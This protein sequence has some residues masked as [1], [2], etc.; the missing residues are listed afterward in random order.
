MFCVE[1]KRREY[2]KRGTMSS[3]E[4]RRS[5]R[6]ELKRQ[7]IEQLLLTEQMS[8]D[9]SS[10]SASDD[11]SQFSDASPK[12]VRYDTAEQ[13]IA[14]CEQAPVRHLTEAPVRELTEAPVSELTEAL[15]SERTEALVSQLTEV[16]DGLLDQVVDQLKTESLSSQPPRP[17]TT[18]S[19]DLRGPEVRLKRPRGRPRKVRN[20]S[21]TV[22]AS[23]SV[24]PESQPSTAAE[25]MLAATPNSD[26]VQVA[27]MGDVRVPTTSAGDGDNLPPVKRPRGRPRKV[28][29]ETETVSASPSVI[30]ESQPSTASEAATPNSDI[31]LESQ[32][33]SMGD[34]PVPTTSAG[35]GDNL[36]PVK[37]PRGR[38][39][40]VKNETETVS[41][42]SPSVIPESQ[43]STLLSTVDSIRE[44][45]GIAGDGEF[46]MVGGPQALTLSLS[47]PP[48][49]AGKVPQPSGVLMLPL[50][51]S[52]PR[53]Q[54]SLM[55][56]QPQQLANLPFEPSTA[57]LL[58]VLTP[59]QP[60]VASTTVPTALNQRSP[61]AY[62]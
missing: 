2:K 40:K 56:V 31:V 4:Q 32:V 55:V 38:P 49:P 25:T 39:R 3:G 5:A 33:A 15:V 50:Y 42:A 11:S 61:H 6:L 46:G 27:S 43:P 57:P 28:R 36:P 44:L 41:S 1:P 16:D 35:D 51:S 34:V 26:I 47:P 7:E 37:R 21:E 54:S 24:I 45:Y 23:P 8:L 60:A 17:V 18:T 58:P 52:E 22:S 9:D 29:N 62:S 48:M 13:T 19:A 53:P 59:N 10:A 30:L 12:R 14:S 20:E